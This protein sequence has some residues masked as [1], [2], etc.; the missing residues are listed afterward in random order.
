LAVE[1]NATYLTKEEDEEEHSVEMMLPFLYVQLT[2]M[3]QNKTEQMNAKK[4]SLPKLIP[5]LV[6]SVMEVTPLL[7]YFNDPVS[8]Q[9]P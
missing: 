5:L 2:N 4:E 1:L 6:G 9:I 3:L 7:K 8:E